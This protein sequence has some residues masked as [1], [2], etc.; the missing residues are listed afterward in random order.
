MLNIPT[1][2]YPFVSDLGQS[3]Q[4]VQNEREQNNYTS[5]VAS[6]ACFS[7]V[8][9]SWLDGDFARENVCTKLPASRIV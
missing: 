6:L 4:I 8:A 2:P 5:G 9:L 7:S 3:N 1:T